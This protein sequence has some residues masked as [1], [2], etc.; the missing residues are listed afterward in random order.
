LLY[1][2]AVPPLSVDNVLRALSG[3]EQKLNLIGELLC[4]PDSHRKVIGEENHEDVNR[5][6][7]I[8]TYWLI[9]CPAATWRYLCWALHG[10]FSYVMSGR[11]TFIKAAD[12]IKGHM[13]K[14]SG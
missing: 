12:G 10:R 8:V 13:E 6:R 2:S 1:C 5:L 7:A 14:L 9:R 3:L 11:T 4:V